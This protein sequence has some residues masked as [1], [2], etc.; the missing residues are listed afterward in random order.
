LHIFAGGAAARQGRDLA[1]R[2]FALR[3]DREQGFPDRTGGAD[4]GYVVLIRH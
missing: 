2:E 4:D 1:D 3:Q